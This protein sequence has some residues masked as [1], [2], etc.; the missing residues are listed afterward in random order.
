MVVE[1]EIGSQPNVQLTYCV[2]LVEI[3]VFVLDAAP[4]AHRAVIR[5]SVAYSDGPLY[6]EVMGGYVSL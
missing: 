5:V 3:D 4:K 6:P 2:S 1:V